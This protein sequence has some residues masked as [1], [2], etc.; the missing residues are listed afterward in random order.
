MKTVLAITVLGSALLYLIGCGP[1]TS[2]DNNMASK[3]TPTTT[4]SPA[5]L[6][7]EDLAA[8]TTP[9]NF[10][11]GCTLPFESIK[12]K[13][14]TID[15]QC[16]K[17]GTAKAN[18]P[19]S[20][21][22]ETKNNFC[23]TG[24]PVELSFSTFDDL[25]SQASSKN[26]S[27]GGES[28]L[29]KDRSVL[30][31]LLS[32]NGKQ[33]GEGT[34]VSLTATVFDARHSNVSFFNETGESVNCKSGEPS[35]NDIHIELADPSNPSDEC[36]TVT[37]E[38]SP[39]LRPASWDRFDVNPTTAPHVDGLT[40][41]KGAKV[42]ISGQLFFDASHSPCVNGHGSAPVRRSIWEIH[43]VYA[44]DVFDT[45]KNKFVALDTWAKGK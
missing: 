41:L 35:M 43:P 17:D 21:Q 37:A 15:S 40:Q 8:T 25:Q 12:G 3:G 32:V 1:T 23:A 27:F 22:N 29:P 11:P 20:L 5:S 9:T 39:H 2:T 44:I 6:E 30:V 31:S 36:K 16:G 24:T 26:I 13:N 42:R 4:G 19:G 7:A 14:L 28:K 45:T 10:N 18:S 34:V 38:I 33:I